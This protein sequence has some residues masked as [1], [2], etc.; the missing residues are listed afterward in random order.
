MDI[1][2]GAWPEVGIQE[3]RR[4]HLRNRAAA[5]DGMDPRRPAGMLFRDLWADWLKVRTP[6]WSGIHAFQVGRL[7]ELYILP[8]FGPADPAKIKPMDVRTAFLSLWESKP[9]TCRKAVSC[10]SQ[11]MRHGVALGLCPADP[12]R[13][14]SGAFPRK[15][16][17]VRHS[18]NAS[19][20]T[21][22]W[23]RSRSS[24]AGRKTT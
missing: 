13:D 12:S 23:P 8:A 24:S 17:T 20:R 9:A 4:K 7:G 14:V 10:F 5:R 2:L 22:V 19:G 3:A 1:S 21:P 16:R 6:G 15:A 18:M 11:C